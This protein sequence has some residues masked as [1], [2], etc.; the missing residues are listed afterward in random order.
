MKK[1]FKQLR[2]HLFP[3]KGPQSSNHINSFNAFF[4]VWRCVWQR[5]FDKLGF[6]SS[7]M[8]HDFVRQDAVLCLTN[9]NEAAAGI[10]CSVFNINA[11]VCLEH[12]YL[13]SNYPP[14]FLE[15]LRHRGVTQ[16]LTW[17]YLTVNPA[18]RT[19]S[20]GVS[21]G[22]LV[23]SL[24]SRLLRHSNADCAIAPARRDRKVHRMVFQVGGEAIVSNITNH[25]V[26][27]D[28][29]SVFKPN[30]HD[31]QHRS[32]SALT[33]ELWS[34]RIDESNISS[35]SSDAVVRS[36]TPAFESAA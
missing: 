7:N 33:R 13:R 3:G 16:V 22:Q 2:C 11:T 24:A 27:C 12:T 35:A 26:P 31:F 17:E 1:D 6:D 15:A 9:D 8:L 25:N 5:E 19:R 28:L 14:P 18:W 36:S 4:S 23:L 10:L 30:A 34:T 21:L 20:I 32:V 29:V